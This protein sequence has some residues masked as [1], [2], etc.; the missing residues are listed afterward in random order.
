MP[1]LPEV[2]TVMRGL[3]PA[4][5]GARFLAVETRRPDLRFPFPD[6]F[7]ERLAGRAVAALSRRAKYILADLDDASVLVVHLGMTGRF[8]VETREASRT[9]GEFY[10]EGPRDPTH[11]HV[12]FRLSNGATVTF[13]D[14]RRFGFMDL[15]P[16]A[17]IE[18]HRAFAGLGVEPLSNAFGGAA[19]RALFAGRRTSLKAALLDQRLIAGIGNIYASEALHRARLGPRRLAGSL[20]K[21]EAERL[22]EAVRRVLAD[23]VEAGG[24][25]LRDFVHADG[26]R[27]AF[28]DRFAVYDREGEPCEACGTPIR[29]IVQ[30]ARSTF[31]C[32]A[33][34][35]LARG[36]SHG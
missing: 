24:S 34:Q 6:R 9:P 20:T 28:Q 23:A 33:C 12:V 32:P 1:E 11:D 29:R 3:R 30:G 16:R 2:E 8:Q 5:E 22:A 15:V 19:L 4:F 17:E 35:R 14:A 13:N 27:G 18:R 7:A 10:Y 26:G 25:T 21:A 31:Y 36:R